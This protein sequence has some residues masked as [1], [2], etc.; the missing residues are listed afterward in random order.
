[1]ELLLCIHNHQ[2]VGNMDF[3]LEEAYE[4]AY[5]PFLDVLSE[6]KNIK[7][8]LHFSGYLLSW[9][10]EHK[11]PYVETI[12]DM[13]DQGM[14]E[15][16]SGAMYE[17]ILS[18]IN[19]EDGISQIKMHRDYLEN[20]FGVSPRGMWLAER[21]YEPHMPKTISRAGIEYIIVDDNHFKAVGLTEDELYGYYIT[22]YEGSRLSV[23]PGLEVLRYAIPF[24]PLEEIDGYFRS[25][26]K[27]KKRL[28]VFGDDGEKFGLWPGTFDH[29]YKAK[30][31]RKFFEYLEENISWLKTVTFGEFIE[32]NPPEGR[33]YLTCNSYKEMAEW[34]LPPSSSIKYEHYK[35]TADEQLREF[36][37]GG[38]FKHF[39]VKYE[40][41]NDMHKKMLDVSMRAKRNVEAR[42]QVFMGQCNDSYWHG[43]FG[44]L[45]LPHLRASVYSHLIEAEKLLA[46]EKPFIN[47]KKTDI[48]FDGIDEIIV[49]NNN[50]K[51][52]FYLKEGGVLYELDFKPSS[53]NLMA[54]LKR[55][56]EGYHEKIKKAV[57]SGVAD[58]TKT[59]HDLVISKEEGLD[60]FLHYDWYRR[61]SFIDH[62]M[63]RDVTFDS[64]YKSKYCEP[65]DFVKEMYQGTTKKEKGKIRLSLERKGHYW[66]T[67][68]GST[69]SVKK[70]F[71]FEAEKPGFEVE[72]R[73]EGEPTEPF[74]FGVEFNFSLLGTGGGRFMETEGG[75][76]DLTETGRLNPTKYVK[77]HDP[78]QHVEIF[79][80]FGEQVEVWTHPVEV[81]SLSEYGFERNYQSTMVLPIWPI[82][83]K[84]GER[85][86][87]IRL[88]LTKI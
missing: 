33:V 65:G 7:I 2:P 22:E 17:P 47:C 83:L 59:I 64:F 82:D 26:D 29:V 27:A 18:L 3:I 55:R 73:I 88:G 14:I 13:I 87:K 50:L 78:Y 68:T 77:L 12:R 75:R 81:V 45:Y 66:K 76:F 58:G 11:R 85:P 25:L 72:Y 34:C 41:S 21:V 61:A 28:A 16:V 24:K 42:R 37:K 35:S 23:F 70:D 84:E 79:L 20:L 60:R 53:A 48:N 44:G 1:M 38:Y 86:F 52:Y 8:N 46:P 5:R 51:A 74:L 80:E 49:E 6:F 4:R 32:K 71:L 39:L 40:E 30:W 19:E 15:I 54:T 67:D 43:V 57:T 36:I 10:K 9:L 62:V 69:L 63:G 56:Y 31:L